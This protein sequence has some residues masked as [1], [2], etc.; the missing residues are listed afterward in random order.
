[1]RQLLAIARRLPGELIVWAVRFYQ[2]SLGLIL[3]GHCR[4]QPSCSE[5]MIG[6]VRK[7]GAILGAARGCWRICR[8]HPWSA[9]G[10]D[11]P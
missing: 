9:G 6:A 5:Y 7:H 11:P 3:G 4:F 8:C 2:V 1:M 10:Y